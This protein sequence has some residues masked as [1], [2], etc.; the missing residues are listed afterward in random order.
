M[1][2]KKVSEVL[3]NRELEDEK[4]ANALMWLRS[5]QKHELAPQVIQKLGLRPID[6]QALQYSASPKDKEEG[7]QVFQK[8]L[9][10]VKQGKAAK[11]IVNP[12]IIESDSKSKVES[13]ITAPP[14]TDA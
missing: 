13:G 6:L 11:D 2:D 9:A 1:A 14:Q 7:Q 4:T 5:N 10:N 3:I 8:I 12:P